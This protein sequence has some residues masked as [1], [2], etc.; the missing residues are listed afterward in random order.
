MRKNYNFTRRKLYLPEYGRHIHEMVDSLLEIEDRHERTRQAKAVIAVMGNLNPTLRDTEDFKHKLWDH[1]FIMSDFRLDVDSPYPQPSRQD[2]TIVPQ[3]LRYPQSRITFKH[4]G[5]YLHQFV[6]RVAKE[7]NGSAEMVNL[8][9]YM[10]TKSYEFNNEHPNN[11]SIVRDIRIMAGGDTEMDL[12][13][14]ANMRSEYR[15]N[16]QQRNTK[17]GKQQAQNRTNNGRKNAKS[18][19]QSAGSR[20]GHANRTQQRHAQHK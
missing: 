18:S 16:V 19:N 14:I 20:G 15:S 3:K 13:T 7:K 1:L 9:R 10:R 12:S 2:L 4:Y 17:R 11:E 6:D 8:A 5:K